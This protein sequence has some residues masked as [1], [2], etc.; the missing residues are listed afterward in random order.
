MKKL[1]AAVTGAALAFMAFSPQ[2]E[3][4]ADSAEDQTPSGIYY[5]EI[6]ASINS[7][8]AERE[9]GLASCEVCVFDGDGEIYT[10][11]YGFSNIEDGVLADG[12]TV[13]EWASTSKI[14]VW[15]SVV[16]TVISGGI[17]LKEYWSYIDPSK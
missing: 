4:L 10:G 16:L 2:A 12:E 9:A 14:L 7:Y 6:G 1:I 11:Y 8:I 17:Y 5:S 13:Y 3:V 15:I